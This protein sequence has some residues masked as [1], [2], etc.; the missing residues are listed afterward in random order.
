MAK[1]DY[2]DILGVSKTSTPEEIKKAYRKLAL[3]Y[4][5]DKNP[6]N[7]EAEDKFKEAAEAYE[8]LSDPQ[9]R[10]QYDQFGHSGADFTGGHHYSNADEVFE[11]FG[12]IFG[13]FFGGGHQSRSRAKK[14]SPT[15][16]NGSDLSQDVSISLQEAFLGTKKVVGVY[17][18]QTCTD[19][20]ATGG[21]D[22]AKATTCSSCRG[23][24]QVMHQQG[25][26]SFAKPCTTCKGQGI[27]ITNPCKT[28]SGQSR[29]Q[30]HEKLTVT[31]PAGI[32]DGA[33][34]RLAEKGDAGVFGGRSGDLYIR[35][36][37][38]AHSTFTRRE[39]DLVTKL[40]LT[41][42]QLVLGCQIEIE[43]IDGTKETLKI[44]SGCQ[45]GKEIVM[46][47]K[48]FPVLGKNARGNLVIITQC[49]IP[50]KLTAEAKKTLL[51]FSS[52]IDTQNSNSNDGITGFFKKFL[53]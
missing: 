2:Y 21:A 32:F 36:H 50:T 13:S 53:G 17:R 11:Q 9:K 5:P 43:S 40:T 48:G 26:F 7:K 44:P 45:V 38:A 34:L 29:V 24:G 39:N 33:Q 1:R 42:P 22:G 35:T 15:A 4:H 16:Q 52:H 37:I 27:I 14:T 20:N 51:E 49:H 18:Y 23:H 19:C 28:C 25:F 12:D 8:T 41:Y 31:I 30:K 6:N 46:P 3:Q 47:G 10:Q